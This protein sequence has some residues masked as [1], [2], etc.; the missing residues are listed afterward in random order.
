MQASTNNVES[1]VLGS[2]TS[3]DL[4][5]VSRGRLVVLHD[6]SVSCHVH[7]LETS[8]VRHPVGGRVSRQPLVV[9]W[10]VMDINTS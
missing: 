4:N 9:L 6:V 7:E 8:W 1:A 2:W 3:D 10:A 5:V